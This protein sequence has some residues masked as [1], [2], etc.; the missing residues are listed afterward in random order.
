[1]RRAMILLLTCSALLAADGSTGPITSPRRVGIGLTERRL[2]LN[3]AIELAMRAN[4][5]V[6]IERTNT[7]SA[8]VQIRGA[9]GGFDPLLRFQPTLGDANTPAASFLDGVNGVAT[10]R[11]FGQSF[12]FHQQT[13]WNGLALDAAFD[14]NR[15]TSGNPF[16]SLS[17]FFTSQLTFSITQPLMRGR[18]IDEQRALVVIRRRDH[19]ASTAELHARAL[20]VSHQV[21]QAYWDLV[22]ARRQ[23]DVD[24]EAAGLART[25]LEQNRR[26]IAAGE[27]PQIELSASEAEFER[28]QDNLYRDTGAI[29]TVEDNLKTMLARDRQDAIWQDEIVPLDSGAEPPPKVIEVSEAVDEALSHRPELKEIDANIAANDV[30]KKQN[31][32]LVRPRMDLVGGYTLAGLAG[33]LRAGVDPITAVA[34][35]LYQRVNALSAGAGL[36]AVS[37]P[38]STG[39]PPALAGGLGSSLSS[40]FGGNYQSVQAGFAIDF[41]ARNRTAR[42]NLSEAAIA[43]KRLGLMRD[44]AEQIIESQVRNALQNLDTARQRMRAASAGARAAKDKLDSETRLFASGEST[45]FLVLTRQNEYSDARRL[46]VE[47]E[48]AFN[49]A[50]A[51]YESALGTTLSARRIAVE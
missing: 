19:E 5:D 20:D 7:D 1:M 40:L 31:A 48:A 30:R 26:M 46:V 36:P 37:A 28:R 34:L 16:L 41:T 25:E 49:K 43:G 3:E 35:P 9:Q 50:V 27:L 13:P 42:A 22:A 51:Q 21:Q 32:D 47:S 33:N 17:P 23:V 8:A 45:N 38:I 18:T 6:A 15:V 4:L 39:L 29:T 14:N 12:A 44:R 10:Q 2:T 24:M 11:V